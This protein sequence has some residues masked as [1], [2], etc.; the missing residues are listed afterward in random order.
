M[1]E[2]ILKA[3]MQLFAVVTYPSDAT[4]P[5]R[6]V[7]EAFLK[8]QLNNHRATYFLG[9]FDLFYSQHQSKFAEKERIQRRLAATSVKALKIASTVNEELTYYQKLI[10]II[11][12]VEFLN[13]AY[14]VLPVERDFID[15]VAE[16]LHIDGQDYHTI[17]S[18]IMSNDASKLCGEEYLILSPTKRPELNLKVWEFPHLQID[19][20][21]AN[22]ISANILLMKFDGDVEITINGQLA[23]PN[24]VH[25]LRPGATVRGSKSEPIYYSDLIVR[26][27]HREEIPL[28]SFD[29]EE[30]SFRFSKRKVGLFPMS[31]SAQSGNLVGIM[32][33]S[34]AGKT[35]LVNLL[36]GIY[37]PSQGHVRLNGIDI[38][39]HPH[40]V[41]GLIG[42]V[43]QDDLLIEDLTVFQNLFYNAKLCFD[44][45][46]EAEVRLKVMK[47]LESLGLHDTRNMKVGSPLN[48]NI[49]GGQRKRLNIA[50]E[51]I[52]EPSVLFLDEPTSGLS[53]RDSENIVDLLKELSAK[54]KLVFV[55]IHQP[56]S[57][58]FKMFNH[59][60][61]LDTG[62]YL[63]YNGDALSCIPYFKRC[64]NHAN[65][66]EG[67]CP[68]CG[69]VNAEQVLSIVHAKVVDE[70]GSF[71][72][73]RK[74]EPS[75]WYE[76]HNHSFLSKTIN[77]FEKYTLPKI[78]FK[79]PSRFKQFWIFL[80]RDALSKFANKQYLAIN[81][82]ETPFLA[83]VLALL[84]R[85][86]DIDE[87]SNGAYVFAKNPNLPV[88][89]IIAVIIAFFVG[90]TMGAEEIINDRKILKRESFLN[91]SRL[92]YICSKVVLLGTLSAIQ[93]ALFVVIGNAIMGIKDMNW[94]YWAVLFST[95]VFANLL[96]LIISDTL[97]KTVNIYILIPFLIIP[98][99]ILSGVFVN[100]DRLNPNFSNPEGI[101]CYGEIIV[102]RWAFEALAV[103]QYVH[104]RY[105]EPFF[106]MEM[107]KSKAVYMRD[108]WVPAMQNKV[109]ECQNAPLTS[110]NEVLLL[111]HE[112]SR[113]YWHTQTLPFKNIE[114][115]D[116]KQIDRTTLSEISEYLV[117]IKAFYR[118]EYNVVDS[119]IDNLRKRLTKTDAQREV[120]IQLKNNYYNEDLERFLKGSDKLF[121]NKIIEYN[122]KFVQKSDPI[123]KEPETQYLQ[124]HYFAPFKYLG[125]VKMSTFV[126]NLLVVWLLNVAM[127]VVL[128]YKGL[129]IVLNSFGRLKSLVAKVLGFEL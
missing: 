16:I 112:L 14:G 98:Q 103:Q 1:S 17:V 69:N 116:P 36:C 44:N 11:Q 6:A 63:I 70:Y 127:L 110:N 83:F 72:P 38:H 97:K 93:M 57:D 87:K 120:F 108:Y 82:F 128:Y 76:K 54:G 105:Q 58:V 9:L 55:V 8:K 53:S 43:S 13:S 45:L 68:A 102:S 26:F 50:L 37:K 40:D 27:R 115:L 79:I 111:R 19:L 84:L 21:V 77:R 88:Y 101:P 29:V 95:A 81:G 12:L 33:D 48:K 90:L 39:E 35:T 106:D 107:Q 74:I 10:V 3:L 122:N 94:H 51:L 117:T 92:G 56:S 61:V 91:L 119:S 32:G 24:K 15:N 129:D 18:F 52:R 46:S 60:L 49:S 75:E 89:M 86:F 109:A 59:L 4:N 73:F 96:G 85:F 71:T 125:N 66:E 65:Y 7:V 64:M 123:F 28:L 47:L 41:E 126:A 118:K 42:Y 30:L 100:Y 31:F 99:L 121:A 5:R 2:E 78:S 67:E 25:V 62:G 20:F 104:N 114:M 113:D 23:E 34:G 22:I 80:Q 124:A